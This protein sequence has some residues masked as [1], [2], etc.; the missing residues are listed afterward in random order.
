MLRNL[1]NAPLPDSDSTLPEEVQQNAAQ[2]IRRYWVTRNWQLVLGETVLWV[3]TLFQEETTFPELYMVTA[4]LIGMA[5][6]LAFQPNNLLWLLGTLVLFGLQGALV[7]G[8]GA[9]TALTYMIPYTIAGMI[10]SGRKRLLL[11][12]TCVFA[13]W[14]SLIY[15]IL[16]VLPQIQ[17]TPYVLV[18]YNI[19]LATYT[20]QTLRYLNQLAVNINSDYVAEKVRVQSQQFLARVSHELRTPLNSMLGFS[21]LLRR[22]ELPAPQTAYLHH[23]IEEGEHLNKLVSDLLDSAHLS[24][25]KLTLNVE[26]CDLNTIC[27]AVVD[28]HR[29]S[30]QTSVVMV[31]DFASTMPPC[32]VDPMRIRQAVGNLVTNAVK[33]TSSG[34]VTVRTRHNQ[35]T[36]TIDVIDTG[37]GISEEAQ[38]LIFVPFVQMDTRQAGVGLGLDIALQLIRLHGGDI[39]LESTPG[40]GSCFTIELPHTPA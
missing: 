26:P 6:L 35:D 13:F 8:L 19:L 21:K 9:V 23:V 39:H 37:T 40:K 18:S 27:H 22:T 33:H 25:G 7:G 1:F 15:E 28:E 10:M 17:P 4:A 11:Q 20:F 14:S 38:R 5:Y 34:S 2:Q 24:T 30:L 12:T 3:A 16:P 29:Q 31:T 32:M 36:V